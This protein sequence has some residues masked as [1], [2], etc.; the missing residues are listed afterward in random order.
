MIV[1]IKSDY[2]DFSWTLRKAPFSPPKGSTIRQGSSIGFYAN[3]QQYVVYFQDGF[4]ELSYP[5]S[6]D[7]GFNYLD[8]HGIVSPL[9]AM[10]IF[11]EYFRG[12]TDPNPEKAE[13]EPHEHEIEIITLSVQRDRTLETMND[14][15]PQFNV[16]FTNYSY[17]KYRNVKISHTGYLRDL[18]AYTQLFLLVVSLDNREYLGGSTDFVK[19]YIEFITKLDAPYFIR[20]LFKAMLIRSRNEFDKVKPLLEQSE[21]LEL[22]LVFGDT[23]CSRMD[24]VKPQITMD[25]VVDIGCGHDARYA[26]MLSRSVSKYHAVDTDPEALESAQRRLRGRENIEYYA[27]YDRVMA[28]AKVDIVISEVLEH[29]SDVYEA[30]RFITDVSRYFDFNKII[31]T[32]PN[33]DFNEHYQLD[34]ELRRNDHGFEMD[35]E[36][37]DWFCNFIEQ[38]V[39]GTLDKFKIGDKV[40]GV[41]P[42]HGLIIYQD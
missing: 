20:Y 31:I 21:T 36:E 35:E 15:F 7:Q 19:K 30:L 29:F 22:E 37:F 12:C 23:H 40:N 24:W 42:T 32:T 14:Y 25:E 5:E 41:S 39:S 26:K 27:R 16:A 17:D 6:S 1:S 38:Y 13:E 2:K 8:P 11:A 34:D 9:A 18:I 3:P 33:R 10:N 28:D 4:D